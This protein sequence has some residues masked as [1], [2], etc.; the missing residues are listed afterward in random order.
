MISKLAINITT[1]DGVLVC[2]IVDHDTVAEHM[3]RL[4]DAIV[5]VTNVRVGL[6]Y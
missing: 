1:V 3:V 6:V 4:K 5:T 2:I